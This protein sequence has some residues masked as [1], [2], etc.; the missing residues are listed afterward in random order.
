VVVDL[1][2]PGALGGLS[3]RR[4]LLPAVV[5]GVGDGDDID[6]SLTAA[7]DI[8]LTDAVDPSVPWVSARGGIDDGIAAVTA[9]AEASPQAAAT[10]VQVLRVGQRVNVQA[11]ITLESIAYGLLQAGTE[12]AGWLERRTPKP[13]KPSEGPVVLVDR[14]DDTL[15]ITLN[16]PGVHNAY[17]AAMRDALV[18]ALQ[19]VVDDPSILAVDLRGAGPSFSSGGDLAEFGTAPDPTS[20]HLIRTTRSAAALLTSVSSRVTAHVH[21]ACMGAGTELPA[22]AKTVSAAP[23]ATFS[24]PEVGM[25]L[26]PGAGGTASIPRRIGRHRTAWLALTGSRIDALTALDWGL[27]DELP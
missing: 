17:D 10:L 7:T 25:G 1:A 12:F 6:P 13:H 2:E 14:E 4:P 21:G 16:R 9:A 22:F 24:L 27:V 20:A 3:K 15:T 5:V 8:L 26:I 11:A 19:L 23:G 18:E